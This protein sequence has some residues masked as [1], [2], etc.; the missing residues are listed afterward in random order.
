MVHILFTKVGNEWCRCIGDN[1]F[2]LCVYVHLFVAI[3][4][5][6]CYLVV[7]MCGRSQ[8]KRKRNIIT[9]QKATVH[10]TLTT[11]CTTH[12]LCK[13]TNTTTQNYRVYY[14]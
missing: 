10:R 5:Q 9:L 13:S 11:F 2:Y 4:L 7:D 8:K 12:V 6:L 14:K 3:L 1:V